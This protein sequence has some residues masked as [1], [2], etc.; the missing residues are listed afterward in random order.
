MI[1]SCASAGIANV[2]MSVRLYPSVCHTL[3]L[4]QNKQ[5]LRH[6]F[7][8]DG[9][10]EYSSFCKYQLQNLKGV[11]PSDGV[12]RGYVYEFAIFRSLSHRISE[13]AQDRTKCYWSLIGS[14]IRPFNW[15]QNQRPWL[16]DPVLTL[17]G[18]LSFTKKTLHPHHVQKQKKITPINFKTQFLIH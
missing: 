14:R 11:T 4:Y 3:L 17:N 5:S 18:H 6:D 16:I 10:P 13:T 1:A 9:E 7:F 12:T 2:E 15:Y 8:T